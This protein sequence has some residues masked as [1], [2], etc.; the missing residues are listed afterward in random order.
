[1]LERYVG[2][3]DY[4]HG[5]LVARIDTAIIALQQ[6]ISQTSSRMERA[7]S[8]AQAIALTLE[9]GSRRGAAVELVETRGRALRDAKLKLEQA[10]LS[11]K[12]QTNIVRAGPCTECEDVQAHVF[13]S[14][15][16]D[17][18]CDSCFQKIHAKG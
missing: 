3:N 18:Y 9:A 4:A 2:K 6:R 16:G 15:C 11:F 10:M 7:Q 1:M 17:A 5:D 8:T 14:E 12:R 13:C